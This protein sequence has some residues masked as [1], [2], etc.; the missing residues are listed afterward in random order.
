MNRLKLVLNATLVGAL[1]FVV[2]GMFGWFDSPDKRADSAAHKCQTAMG[3]NMPRDAE[4]YCNAA[5]AI[6]TSERQIT[7][8]TTAKVHM[9][10]SA[11]RLTQGKLPEALAHCSL[12][13]S[14]WRQV[15]EPLWRAQREKDIKACESVISAA[16]NLPPK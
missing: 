13:I 11:L 6:V 9:Q 14:A 8:K 1:L 16:A 2:A 12:A 15:E 4:D 5:L 10:V 3:I 7:H